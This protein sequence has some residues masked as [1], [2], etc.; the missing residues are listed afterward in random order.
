MPFLP[1]HVGPSSL[2]R[3]PSR[4]PRRSILVLI[5]PGACSSVGNT[6]TPGGLWRTLSCAIALFRRNSQHYRESGVPFRESDV[7][8]RAARDPGSPNSQ[9]YR[10]SGV[11]VRESAVFSRAAGDPVWAGAPGGRQGPPGTPSGPRRGSFVDSKGRFS[12][13]CRQA[14]AVP[15]VQF[16]KGT[17]CA[18]TQKRF[19]AQHQ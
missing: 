6:M 19:V 13:S 16:A 8:Y 18:Q 11:P 3:C 10:E 1:T 5:I 7:F 14:S 17:A 12:P 4:P 15:V 9:H 2:R